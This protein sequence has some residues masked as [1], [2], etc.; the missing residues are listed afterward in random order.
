MTYYFVCVCRLYIFYE[1]GLKILGPSPLM[2]YHF[3]CEFTFSEQQTGFGRESHN[4][5]N[6]RNCPESL[7]YSV[8]T[9]N[10]GA[11]PPII[12]SASKRS[13]RHFIFH[14][15]CVSFE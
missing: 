6:G 4:N 11:V 5:V 8:A 7:G 13:S 10:K 1:F 14:R 9:V 12:P 15:K 3:P 2:A